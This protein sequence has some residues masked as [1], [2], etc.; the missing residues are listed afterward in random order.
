MEA[1]LRLA[2]TAAF[3]EVVVLATSWAG[4]ENAIT[5]AG[6]SNLAGKPVIDVTNPMAFNED[7]SFSLTHGHTDSGGE[8]VQ[9]WM[10]E[11][12][13]VKAFNTV[14]V[15]HMVS[16]S[17]P[18]GPPDLLICGGDDGAKKTVSE[19][20]GALGWHVVDIGGIEGSRG[21]EAMLLVIAP[22]WMATG[23]RDFAFKFVRK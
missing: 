18:G 20:T 9:R 10:P 1:A 8:Q 7:G 17:F 16:P 11:A 15:E 13:V 14:F 12:H 4:T 3:G 22:V 6:P 23:S 5:L 21:L 19:I 2:E